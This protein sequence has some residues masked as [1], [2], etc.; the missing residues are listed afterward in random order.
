[1][2][3]DGVRWSIDVKQKVRDDR[4]IEYVG[5]GAASAKCMPSNS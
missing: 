3:Q 5:C 1:M 4:Q 2:G